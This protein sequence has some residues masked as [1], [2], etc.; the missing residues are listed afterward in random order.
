LISLPVFCRATPRGQIERRDPGAAML[1]KWA[2][3]LRT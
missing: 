2:S 3:G 1:A